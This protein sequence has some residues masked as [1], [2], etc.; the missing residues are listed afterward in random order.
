MSADMQH[1]I[2]RRL[3]AD[4][5]LKKRG[6][7]MRG[8]LCPRCSK[9]TLWCVSEKPYGV[10]CD[11]IESCGYDESV[12]EL[13]PDLFRTWSDRFKAT[14]DNPHAAA[15][16]Y[17][18]D[19][20][21]LNVK[22]LAGRFTQELYR[23]PDTGD[24]TATV[25]FPLPGGSWWQRLIDDVRRFG[26]K[27]ATFAPGKAFKGLCWSL[28]DVAELATADEVWI[29][30]GIFD[31]A[32][33]ELHGI[34]AASAMSCNVYP[35]TFLRALADAVPAG[36]NRPTLVWAF[37]DGRV[38]AD[39]V[40]QF[41]RRARKAGWTCTAALSPSERGRKID[42]NDRHLRGQLTAGHVD[43]WKYHGALRLA[44]DAA[45]KGR[46]IHARKHWASF[47]FD[48]AERVYWFQ[49]DQA[50]YEKA[51][52]TLEDK[53]QDDKPDREELVAE[54]LAASNA[55]HE[56]ANCHPRPLYFQ[57]NSLT[58]ES[59]YYYRVDFPHGGKSVKDTFNG[60]SLSS[61]AE[62][63]KRLLS[64]ASGAIYSGTSDQLKRIIQVQLFN[65]KEVETIDYIGYSREHAMYVFGDLA[66]RQ[67]RVLEI[68]DEDYFDAGK[69][70]L[71]SLNQSVALTVQKDAEKYRTDWLDMLWRCF[72]AKGLVALTFWFGALFAEQI[73]RTEKSFPFVEIIGEAGSGKST[74]VEFLW[75][76]L[77]RTDYE[78]FDP[79]K[80]TAAARARNFAQVSNLPVVLL[81]GDRSDDTIKSRRFDWD[82][83][84]T[85]YNGRS[86]RAVGV[87]NNGNET[88]EPPFR[89][90]IVITQNAA[91]EASDAVMQ[92]IVHLR[93]DRSG[94]TPETGPLAKQLETMPVE[95]VSHFILKAA[96]AESKVLATIAERIPEH[97]RT[98]HGH[99]DLKSVRII[100][101]HAQIL[102]LFDALGHVLPLTDEHRSAFA[103]CIAELAVQRQHAI[104]ADHPYV[105]E[106]WDRFDYIDGD[107]A[108]PALNHSRNPHE[109][110]VNLNHFEQEVA[111]RRLSTS[112][113][114][115]DLKKL[116]RSS[117]HRKFVDV[118]TVNSAIWTR[119]AQDTRGKS[120]KCWVFQRAPGETSGQPA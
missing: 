35:E 3:Q 97:Q 17:L 19:E 28:R 38:A 68:N 94:H 89:G 22:A 100:K 13:Y 85:A 31:A 57:R 105:A 61:A 72:G 111:E 120:V 74:L 46:L 5:G 29:V 102:A 71:K 53:Y 86:V 25:R 87:K 1:D 67:G 32:A 43:T 47:F 54:A 10:R 118:K 93:F 113:S 62:F 45:E 112:A 82:E 49:L 116:L 91:V 92:R 18:R 34:A 73:R 90:A 63:M 42:W 21:G 36:K 99:A 37:D 80:S 39:Y 96:Q 95:Q 51:M 9:K 55:V 101:N 52:R 23:D 56:I 109:I 103:A 108:V 110:A 41:A 75:K 30:E 117:R 98:L 16:A 4:F 15:I 70:S 83:L 27:K 79:S 81:E 106:F 26:K 2:L 66:V 12:K 8:G 60:G 11:R 58:G 59:W 50:S 104:N 119:G 76:L 115:A 78:G 65:L 6:D 24:T 40:R 69:L 33:L 14:P 20:R 114:S 44:K 107:G 88:R 64:I 48:F 84:K 7:Y 77:G